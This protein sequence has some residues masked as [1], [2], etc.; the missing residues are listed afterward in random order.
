MWILRKGWSR[1]CREPEAKTRAL[2]SFFTSGLSGAGDKKD[3]A[4]AI[5]EKC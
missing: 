4:F 2:R 5:K 1:V 3:R